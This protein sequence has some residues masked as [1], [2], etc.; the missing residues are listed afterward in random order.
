MYNNTFEY[1][2]PCDPPT[3]LAH[4][5]NGKSIIF[6]DNIWRDINSIAP[7]SGALFERLLMDYI[8]YLDV[9]EFTHH[10]I[11]RFELPW[12]NI[13]GEKNYE[14]YKLEKLRSSN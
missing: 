2:L 9:H 4:Y 11:G 7:C 13:K 6:V 14:K 10:M 5:N 12:I 1:S 3:A 8:T